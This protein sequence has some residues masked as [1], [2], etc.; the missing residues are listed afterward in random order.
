MKIKWYGHACFRIEGD[1]IAIVTDPY[2]PKVAGLNPIDEPADIVVMSSASD[3]FHSDASV[4]P[5]E[6]KILN[7]LEISSREQ[8]EVNGVTFEALPTMESLTYKENPDENAIYRFELEGIS[9]LHLGDLGNP[10]TDEQLARLRGRVDVLLALT[11]GP[12]TIELE[13][14][15]RTIEEIG[16]RVVIPMHYQIP[17]LKLGILP[18]EAFT[19]RYP[20]NVVTRIGATEVELSVG[21]LPGALRIYVLEPAG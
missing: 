16:P 9:M 13:D 5:G 19:S 14:L 2:T 18:L 3:R 4:V 21:T 8:V 6:P 11:G 17:K 1:G 20:E 12:P 15:D 7:A 10:L